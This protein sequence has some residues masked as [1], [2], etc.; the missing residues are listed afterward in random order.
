M[1]EENKFKFGSEALNEA[2]KEKESNYF[3]PEIGEV[4]EVEVLKDRE[5]QEKQLEYEG[6]PVTKFDI[7]IIY[8]N[9]EMIW[10]V[11]KRNLKFIDEADTN[12]FN[13]LRTEKQYNII[14]LKEK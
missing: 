11:G 3:K 14:P 2:V 1:I 8:D 6:K 10:S 12:K 7:T 13:V 4:Y 9:K 5:I